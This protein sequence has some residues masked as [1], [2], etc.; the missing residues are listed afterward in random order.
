MLRAAPLPLVATYAYVNPVVAVILG[1]LVLGEA[2]EPRTVLAGGVIIFAVALIVTARGRMTRPREVDAGERSAATDPRPGSAS[3]P[4]P[5][6]T[7]RSAP[8]P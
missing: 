7:P 8:T 2:I 4:V 3:A 5:A 6:P 1:S